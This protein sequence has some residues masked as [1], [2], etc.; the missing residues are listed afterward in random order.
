MDGDGPFSPERTG[1]L[2]V[3][4][5]I[6]LCFSGTYSFQELRK[7]IVGR[8]GLVSYL[9]TND[10]RK[11]SEMIAQGNKKAELIYKAMAYQVS[12]EIGAASAV[13][14]GEVDAIA[15]TGGIAYDSHL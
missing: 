15:I 4:S 2:P 14:R 13:L 9:D 12:K 10:A 8:G 1:S 7:R 5:L 3:G 6:D 11:V